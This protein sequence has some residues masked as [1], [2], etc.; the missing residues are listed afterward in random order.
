M[1]DSFSRILC[2]QFPF[3]CVLFCGLWSGFM[4]GI[5]IHEGLRETPSYHGK[6]YE[7]CSKMLRKWRENSLERV[8]SF[9]REY[10]VTLTLLEKDPQNSNSEES[11]ENRETF[12]GSK[13]TRPCRP[14]L[15]DKLGQVELGQA[16][17]WV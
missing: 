6:S 1:I 5:M 7:R 16:P 12:S 8:L 13:F 10:W 11:S 15:W 9:S 3:C 2:F 4:K 14:T 17:S